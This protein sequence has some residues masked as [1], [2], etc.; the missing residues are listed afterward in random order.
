MKKIG[1]NDPC[2]CGSGK[3]F[4]KCCE[5]KML[6]RKY[7]A[8]KLDSSQK[9]LSESS[10]LTSFFQIRVSKQDP[11]ASKRKLSASLGK[12]EGENNPKENQNPP[13]E[14]DSPKDE[15]N[16]ENQDHS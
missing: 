11:E 15:Q 8:T 9:L 6:G 10:S 2:P 14:S 12:P 5:R 13:P 1:R 16:T 7:M 4:K 3:K